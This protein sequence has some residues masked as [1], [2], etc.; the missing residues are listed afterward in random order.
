MDKF[1]NDGNEEY[2]AFLQDWIKDLKEKDLVFGTDHSEVIEELEEESQQISHK[3]PQ[4]WWM[5]LVNCLT[6]MGIRIL[7]YSTTEVIKQIINHYL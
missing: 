6:K 4:T 7:K 1:K 2:L 3:I 5:R